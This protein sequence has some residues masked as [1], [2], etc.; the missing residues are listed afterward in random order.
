MREKSATRSTQEPDVQL[1]PGAI[2]EVNGWAFWGNQFRIFHGAERIVSDAAGKK[3]AEVETSG[4]QLPDGS[5]DLAPTARPLVSVRLSF[6]GIDGLTA[7][8]AR[9]LAVYLVAAADETDRWSAR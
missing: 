7:V 4:I 9:E 6:D 8:Q 1:P 3:V 2:A 5:I